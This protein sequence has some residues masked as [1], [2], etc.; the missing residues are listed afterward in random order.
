MDEKV[1]CLYCGRNNTIKKGSRKLKK[2][3]KP[4]YYCRDCRHKFSF[5]LGKKKFDI[6]VILN[7]VCFYNRGYNYDEVCEVVS[8]KHKANVS[9]TSVFRWVKEYDLGY[10][11]IRQEIARKQIRSLIIGR[12]FKHSGLI[13]NFRCHKGKL[14]VFEKFSGLKSFIFSLSRGVD[15]KYF[16]SDSERCSQIK[17]EVSVDIKVFDNI[18][19]NKVIGSALKIV[20]NNRQRHSIIENLMLNCDRNTVAVEVP[21][22]YWDK[23]Q[24]IGI[25]GHIDVLQVKY[26]KIWVLDYKPDAEQEEVDKVVSQLFSYALG[27]SFR[28]GIQLGDIRCGW[29]DENK[30]HTFEASKVKITNTPLTGTLIKDTALDSDS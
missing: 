10:S 22:W 15:E 19:L 18:R 17:K 26:V 2:G 3:N 30:I 11:T 21:V 16:N 8:R 29:F 25:C 14:E 28:T 24:N 5:G 20:K 13:Y 4:I 9:L 6:K 1:R 12:I 7:A 27:L 23:Q